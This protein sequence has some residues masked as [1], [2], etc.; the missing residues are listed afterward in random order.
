MEQR[1]DLSKALINCFL[2]AR[3]ILDQNAGIANKTV[4]GT[5]INLKFLGI[6]DGLTVGVLASYPFIAGS[7]SVLTLSTQMI[8]S[9]CSVLGLPYVLCVEPVRPQ[10]KRIAIHV[11]VLM[12][13]LAG[14][15]RWSPTTCSRGQLLCGTTQEAVGTR[16]ANRGLWFATTDQSPLIIRFRLATTTMTTRI[17]AKRNPSATTRF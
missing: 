3:H 11:L 6:G 17:V 1:S 14:I 16:L 7:V 8:G 12:S 10:P 9:P 5:T 4:N 13:G 15:I 2:L